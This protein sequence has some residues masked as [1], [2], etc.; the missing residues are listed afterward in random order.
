MTTS[1]NPASAWRDDVR[2]MFAPGATYRR[3]LQGPLPTGWR[4]LLTRPAQVALV[5]AGFVSLTNTGGFFP[6]LLLGSLVAW[7]WVPALQMAIATPLIV[8]ARALTRQRSLRL[9]SCI[10]LF[11]AG[12]APWSL[13]LLIAAVVMTANLPEP[14]LHNVRRIL[15]TGLVPILWTWVL[16]FSFGRTVLALPGWLAALGTLLYQAAIWTCAYFY[17]GAVTHRL[18]PFALYPSFLG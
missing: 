11:F 12:H 2:L 1:A 6:S 9:S 4:A 17:V 7:S 8:A 14:L 18:W 10:D 13:W 15:L 16:T 3:L 5:L